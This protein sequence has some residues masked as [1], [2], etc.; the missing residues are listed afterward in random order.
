[1]VSATAGQMTSARRARIAEGDRSSIP[2]P[3]FHCMT[4]SYGNKARHWETGWRAFGQL[5]QCWWQGAKYEP[6]KEKP[7]RN[8]HHGLER[9][10]ARTARRKRQQMRYPFA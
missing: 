10:L 6:V 8:L 4:T 2:P 9:Q 7:D 1:M 5:S 3:P